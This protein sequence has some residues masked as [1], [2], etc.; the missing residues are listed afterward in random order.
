M[1]RTELLNQNVLISSWLHT[2]DN[3]G[4][5]LYTTPNQVKNNM[6]DVKQALQN[7]N[8]NVREILTWRFT[9]DNNLII[10]TN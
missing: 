1:S 8:I 9:S 10:I 4:V 7:L 2:P 3:T 6:V 5:V